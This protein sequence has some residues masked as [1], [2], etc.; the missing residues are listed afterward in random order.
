MEDEY[1]LQPEELP[2]PLL[3]SRDTSEIAGLDARIVSYCHLLLL[4]N[5]TRIDEFLDG[6]SAKEPVDENVSSLPEAVSA[7]HC[8]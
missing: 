4:V 1:V 2:L 5:L 8:L 6:P 3:V 7:V